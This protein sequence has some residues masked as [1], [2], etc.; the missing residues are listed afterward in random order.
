M[1]RPPR[2]AP[3]KPKQP[4][5]PKRPEKPAKRPSPSARA[6]GA[7][8][9]G[10]L[11]DELVDAALR[12][13]GR[14]WAPYSRFL[15]GAALLCEDGTVVEGCNVENVSYGLCICAERTAVAAAVASG[16]RR[17]AAIAI[18]TGSSP[19]SPPCGMC[20]Q[21]LAEFCE[22]LPIVCVNPE[23]ERSRTTLRAIFPGT[24]TAELLQSGQ[25][26]AGQAG[27]AGAPLAPRAR[28]RIGPGR[29]SR[30]ARKAS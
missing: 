30:A 27:L 11:E 3:K 26:E 13:R 7:R 14:A 2:A 6:G 12:A 10:S 9:E 18:A 19:P 23:G 25:A 24:F 5:K 4:K 20:R 15:V 29:G 22:D 1:S 8:G 16:R 21:V 28:P 17:F